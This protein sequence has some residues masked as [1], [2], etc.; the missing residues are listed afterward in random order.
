MHYFSFIC[1][2]LYLLNVP[3][4]LLSISIQVSFHILP[5]ID[6]L[7]LL[8]HLFA[9][10]TVLKDRAPFEVFF[11]FP[12]QTFTLFKEDRRLFIFFRCT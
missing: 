10:P 5:L 4:Y 12:T 9:F 8:F 7:C 3:I 6:F 2:T 11:Y 1:C